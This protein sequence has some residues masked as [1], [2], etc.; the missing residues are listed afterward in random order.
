MRYTNA[1]AIVS[2][3]F[4][5]TEDLDG[6]F[7]GWD[8]E[9][10]RYDPSRGSTRAWR[11]RAAA[12]QR[13]QGAPRA[14][15]PTA[16]TGRAGSRASRPSRTTRCSTRAASSRSCAALRALHAGDGGGDL[17]RP[18]RALPRGRRGAVR[19]L[20]PRA[21]L[22]LLLRG[23][24]DP[25]HPRR[26]EHPRRLDPPA[27]AGQH[28]PAGRRHPGAARPRVH[29]GL[30]RHPDA[31]QHPARLPADAGGRDDGSLHASS[32]RPRRRPASGATWA[33]TRLAAQGVVG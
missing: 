30:D 11:S 33:P 24:L 5:D 18:A 17:R 4:R 3:D 13:E 12:G 9:S 8:P 14:R 22:G 16:R 7:S 29:P 2:D 26:A 1:A 32:S 19:Q 6:L 23:R 10:G 15:R 28:R 21:H 20:G 25:A 31:L 27:A